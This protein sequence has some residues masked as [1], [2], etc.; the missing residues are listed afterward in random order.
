M[1]TGRDLADWWEQAR[2]RGKPFVVAWTGTNAKSQK[3]SCRIR[4]YKTTWPNPQPDVAIQSIDFEAMD[5]QASPFLVAITL[6]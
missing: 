1:V 4:L 6:E 5:K 3:V 2:D